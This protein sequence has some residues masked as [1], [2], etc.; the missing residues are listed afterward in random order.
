M[1]LINRWPLIADAND[2][3][4]NFNLTN[5]GTVTFSA[6]GASFNGSNQSL[7]GS[8]SGTPS[9]LSMSIWVYL[10][11]RDAADT[12]MFWG[13]SSGG[14]GNAIG[15]LNNGSN[16]YF[17]AG[18]CGK[19]ISDSGVYNNTNM[20]LSS[21]LQLGVCGDGST[22]KFIINGSLISGTTT[23][24]GG[25]ACTSF[26]IGNR[27]GQNDWVNMLAKDARRYDHMLSNTEWSAL[28]AAGSN[29][30]IIPNLA[31]SGGL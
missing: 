15:T 29:P 4:G 3:I 5:N 20:P 25:G 14:V 26:S 24:A 8:L 11:A 21:W 12:M 31:M 7:T 23:T 1:S 30:L 28:Y 16:P 22:V 6:N 10:N 13:S 9:A 27:Y 18:A 2:V 19:G 17:W